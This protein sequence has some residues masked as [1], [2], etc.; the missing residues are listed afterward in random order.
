[1]MKT[2]SEYRQYAQACF[3]WATN[4][5]SDNDRGIFLEMARVWNRIA[6][7]ERDVMRQCVFER[8]EASNHR[9]HA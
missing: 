6:L 9:L 5:K 4:A 3:R 7:V 1:M 2:V 8:F